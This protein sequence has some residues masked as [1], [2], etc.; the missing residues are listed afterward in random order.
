[1]ARM[2][3][4]LAMLLLAPVGT[5]GGEPP[6]GVRAVVRDA[7]DG[8]TVVL[9]RSPDGVDKVRLV[10]VQ[11][12]KLPLDRAGYPAWPLAAEAREAL[13]ALVHGRVVTLWF[14]GRPLDRHRRWLAHL[15]REDGLWVQ[16]EMLRRGLVRVYTF[17]D[18]RARATEMLALE[19]EARA[20]GRGIWADRHYAVRPA[21]AVD[22]DIDSFQLVEGRISGVARGRDRLYLN[23]GSDWRRDFTITVVKAH[24]RTFA[25]AGVDPSGFGGR[26][27]R[28]RGWIK[29]FNGPLIEV[30]HPEQ[31]ELLD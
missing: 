21:D 8:D 30:T 28:V 1:M 29:S 13:A 9:D 25:K 16:G 14:G 11:A 12:P 7:I 3:I 22:R 5:L 17:E 23:F 15:V 19:R 18:N 4:L 20:A 27:V 10:G 31:I 2:A 26:L 24:E 6:D